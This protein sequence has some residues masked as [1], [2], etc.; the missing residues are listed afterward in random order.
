MKTRIL[1]IAIMGMVICSCSKKLVMPSGE[2]KKGLTPELA[3]GKNLFVNNCAKCHNLKNPN[4]YTP[5]EW[6]PILMRMQKKAKISDSDREK[7]YN[8]VTYK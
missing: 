2:E 5:E 1:A 8:Y 7:I 6:A 3:E 4:K